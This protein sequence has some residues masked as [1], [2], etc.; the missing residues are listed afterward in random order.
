MQVNTSPSPHL[1]RAPARKHGPCADVRCASTSHTNAARTSRHGSPTH[2]NRCLFHGFNA[3]SVDVRCPQLPGETL[4]F[5]PLPPC[6]A[7]LTRTMRPQVLRA[8][9]KK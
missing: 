8:G 9:G 6:I 2:H 5:W 4:P 3:F 7:L 1:L